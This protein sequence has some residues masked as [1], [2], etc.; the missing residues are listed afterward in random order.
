V[1]FA[2]QSGRSSFDGF[3]EKSCDF[4]HFL[5]RAGL[6]QIGGAGHPLTA[7]SAS[8]AA[9]LTP[10]PPTSLQKVRELPRPSQPKEERYLPCFKGS[11]SGTASPLAPFTAGFS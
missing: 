1:D 8:L 10:S 6:G 2:L 7:L 5:L 11:S 3:G 9:V 4:L